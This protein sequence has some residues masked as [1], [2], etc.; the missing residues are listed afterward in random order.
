[1]F[2]W[3]P[4][5]VGII[6]VEVLD[7]EGERQVFDTTHQDNVYTANY[8]QPV[9]VCVCVGGGGG[10]EVG[11]EEGM[12]GEEKERGGTCDSKFTVPE[13]FLSCLR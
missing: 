13:E 12:G 4:Q 5:L 7:R 10:G 8:E 11:G 6:V 2:P 9:C 3:Q 1:M